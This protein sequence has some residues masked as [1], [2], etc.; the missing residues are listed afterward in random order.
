MVG[1]TNPIFAGAK[2]NPERSRNGWPNEP[3]FCR[4]EGKFV[5]DPKWLAETG[6][7]CWKG[8]NC[9]TTNTGEACRS[10]A[11]TSA[12]HSI[13]SLAVIGVMTFLDS[14][15]ILER[16]EQDRADEH[17]GGAYRKHIQLQGNVHATGL[18]DS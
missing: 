4:C 10:G 13:F 9:E 12:R 6:Q 8:G 2:G 18:P 5:T 16:T 3:N 17:E 14:S 15:R 1:Q 7:F 11:V